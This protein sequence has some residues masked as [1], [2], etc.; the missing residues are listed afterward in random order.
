MRRCSHQY[1]RRRHSLHAPSAE[2]VFNK[3]PDSALTAEP[4]CSWRLPLK[5]RRLVQ[6]A[7]NRSQRGPNSV[8]NAGKKCN[9]PLNS[10]LAVEARLFLS[11]SYSTPRPVVSSHRNILSTYENPS[12]WLGNDLSYPE[13]G[14][15]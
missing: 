14:P 10:R 6:I 12:G 2:T 15:S 4:P 13:G 7:G 9:N 5:L 8:P 1:N 3:E 11:T